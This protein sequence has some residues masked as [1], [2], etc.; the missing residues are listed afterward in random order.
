MAIH[1][2][3]MPRRLGPTGSKPGRRAPCSPQDQLNTGQKPNNFRRIPT[4][5]PSWR[6]FIAIS[7]LVT[8]VSS[9]VPRYS[10]DYSCP[11]LQL[12]I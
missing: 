3:P 8:T 11:T 7:S 10:L 2:R 1:I 5:A 4:N 9:D 6:G 12:L